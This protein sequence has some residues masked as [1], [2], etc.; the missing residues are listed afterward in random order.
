[1]DEQQLIG[2]EVEGFLF[3]PMR[4]V[5]LLSA[6]KVSPTLRHAPVS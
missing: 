5:P 6:R 3:N 1:V 4:A 2:I